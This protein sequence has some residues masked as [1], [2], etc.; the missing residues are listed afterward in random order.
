M[1]DICKCQMNNYDKIHNMMIL[2]HVSPPSF[3]YNG[4]PYARKCGLHIET[5]PFTIALP[6]HY[7]YQ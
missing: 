6:L 7:I 1:G 3:L 2:H 5:G 4:N